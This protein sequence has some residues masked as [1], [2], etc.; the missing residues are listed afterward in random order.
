MDITLEVVG[1][2]IHDAPFINVTRRDM[3]SSDQVAQPLG[4]IRV[5]LVVVG[6]HAATIN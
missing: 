6:R 1:M 4:R 2:D 5:D 3:A